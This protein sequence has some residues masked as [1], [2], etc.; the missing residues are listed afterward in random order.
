MAAFRG[1]E[2]TVLGLA[3]PIRAN[4]YSVSHDYFRLFGGTPVTGRTFAD[5]ESAVGGEP[6]AVVGNK[7]WRERLGGRADVSPCPF[8]DLG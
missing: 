1:G 4:V 2:S 6:V 5:D 3:E 7:F 8:A